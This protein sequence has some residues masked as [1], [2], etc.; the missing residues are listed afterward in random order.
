MY[1][2]DIQTDLSNKELYALSKIAS[3]PAYVQEADQPDIDEIR[4]LPK[5]AFAD[6]YNKA[7]PINNKTNTY[8]S[9]G[10][11]LPK[12]EA[13]ANQWGEKF[14]NEVENNIKEA[15]LLF[16]CEEDINELERSIKKAEAKDY[17]EK[18][19]VAK[20]GSFEEKHTY[21]TKKDL[22]KIAEH[23]D[24]NLSKYPFSTRRQVAKDLLKAALDNSFDELPELILKYA[25]YGYFPDIPQIKEELV[26]RAGK[27]KSAENKNRYQE[28]INNL[29]EVGSNEVI[30]KVAEIVYETERLEGLYDKKKTASVLP[31]PVDTFFSVTIEK[32]ASAMD[33]V[34]VGDKT[35][36]FQTLKSIPKNYYEEVGLGGI[37]FSN[38]K[39]AKEELST[40]PLADFELLKKMVGERTPIVP[41][42]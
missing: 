26:R 22:A 32:A 34:K 2:L 37:D 28:M 29:R 7:F 31:D 12:K 5:E 18:V 21:K 16:G 42:F 13:I 4:K 24:K 41:L 27:L 11:F 20:M 14:A 8:L 35:Y 19:I 36:D 6:K 25:G 23:F 3:F 39:L 10:Y 1:E 40:L 30:F 9:Y 38:P 17:D 15:S 33:V